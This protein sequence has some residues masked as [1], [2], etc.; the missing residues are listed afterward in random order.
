MV[1]KPH[2]KIFIQPS[3]FIKYFLVSVWFLTL[4]ASSP[5]FHVKISPVRVALLIPRRYTYLF[6]M[7]H[8]PFPTTPFQAC[9]VDRY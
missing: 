8:V 4:C 9:C 7:I 3:S 2:N 6:Y 5:H 1:C